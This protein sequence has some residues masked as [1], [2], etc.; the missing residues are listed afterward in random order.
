MGRSAWHSPNIQF[1]HHIQ[2]NYHKEPTWPLS[3]HLA[4]TVP[5]KPYS[6]DASLAPLTLVSSLG[7]G[8]IFAYQPGPVV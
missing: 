8:C 5:T 3:T 1:S 4:T 2:N 7:P 6:A